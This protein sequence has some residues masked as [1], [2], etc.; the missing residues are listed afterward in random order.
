VVIS[1]WLNEYRKLVKFLLRKN[2]ER[3]VGK[4]LSREEA[5]SVVHISHSEPVKSLGLPP[6]LVGGLPHV[7]VDGHSN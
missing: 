2:L 3:Y 4:H 6:Y 1:H 7:F 5:E